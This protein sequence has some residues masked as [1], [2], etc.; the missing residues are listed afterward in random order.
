MC[1]LL[2]GS[3]WALPAQSAPQPP[4][5]ARTLFIT[6]GTELALVEVCGL[7]RETEYRHRVQW[8]LAR[9]RLSAMHKRMLW[10]DFEAGRRSI[11]Q[12]RGMQL[13]EVKES[14]CREAALGYTKARIWDDAWVHSR[15]P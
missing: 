10:D 13:P 2:G 6:L 1:V 15:V 4:F 14:A 5:K 11:Y 3:L 12:S 8:K 9:L 7:G